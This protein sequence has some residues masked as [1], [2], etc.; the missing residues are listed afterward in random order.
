MF[1]FLC[2]CHNVPGCSS[3]PP[4]DL[5]RM[6]PR[7]VHGLSLQVPTVP[8]L[9]AVPGVL[10]EGPGVR[11]AHEPARDEGVLVL[12]VPCQ[13]A[14]TLHRQVLTV[15]VLIGF[16]CF[17]CGL[18]SQGQL[19]AYMRRLLPSVDRCNGKH[20]PD[21]SPVSPSP[22]TPCSP[23]CPRSRWTLRTWSPPVRRPLPAT[24]VPCSCTNGPPTSRTA[25]FVVTPRIAP[26]PS[27]PNRR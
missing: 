14:G 16:I 3:V 8:Q 11:L 15:G 19:R 5:R 10:L 26:G 6:Q 1:V 12:Q 20:F 27:C 21:V 22:C 9:P 17:F 4:G 7:L 24:W 2:S 25:C 23:R 13:A 18:C